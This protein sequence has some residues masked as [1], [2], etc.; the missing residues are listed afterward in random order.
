M[1][2][3]S[4]SNRVWASI[5]YAPTNSTISFGESKVSSNKRALIV[6]DPL[7]GVALKKDSTLAIIRALQ[8]ADW[9]VWVTTRECLQGEIVHAPVS[10]P[11]EQQGERLARE[12]ASGSVPTALAQRVEEQVDYSAIPTVGAT[13]RLRLTREDGLAAI[14]M[15][16]D[17]P[18][19]MDYIFATYILD[20]AEQ[21]GVLVVNAPTALRSFNEKTALFYAAEYTPPTLVSA[22]L[23]EIRAFIDQHGEVVIKPLDGMGGKGVLRLVKGDGNIGSAVDLLSSSGKRMIMVQ[24]YVDAVTEGDTRVFIIDGKAIPWAVARIP[25]GNDVRANMAAGGSTV[26][27]EISPRE[28]TIAEGIAPKLSQ[29]G[30][31]FA[32]LDV[33]GD[34]LTEINV[35]SPTCLRQV[36][37]STGYSIA[38]DLVQALESRI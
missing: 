36:E 19:D 5:H 1:S 26:V 14:F 13:Q 2:V 8:L 10:V 6:M 28:R 3:V 32:G 15:R 38:N 37:D 25:L 9:D 12:Q 18:F 24:R 17:P 11:S 20:I 7:A 21:H 30:I 35:T 16:T 23:D 29:A 33:I 27:R 22:Q 4:I 34:W 31:L